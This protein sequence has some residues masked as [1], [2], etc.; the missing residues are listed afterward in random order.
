MANYR[1][2]LRRSRRR[3]R[4]RRILMVAMW[5]LLNQK[6]QSYY[7]RRLLN[8]EGRQRRDRNL[9]RAALHHPQHSTWEKCFGSGDDGV[10]I[11]VT[12]FDHAT[13]EFMLSHFD[14][15]FSSYT[16]WCS[17][18]GGVDGLNYRCL[19]L[20]HHQ[21]QRRHSRQ[22]CQRQQ[23]VH[24]VQQPLHL[25]VGFL[26]DDCIHKYWL[27]FVAGWNC[28]RTAEPSLDESLQQAMG[29]PCLRLQDLLWE[30]HDQS[31]PC[32]VLELRRWLWQYNSC[33]NFSAVEYH[34]PCCCWAWYEYTKLCRES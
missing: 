23:E 25:G 12:G 9:I 26:T 3:R 17:K 19:L 14:P 4:R 11:T 15:L 7:Y 6:P 29:S 24:C 33:R 2:Y 5:L 20:F 18:F 21:R 30:Q 34:G 10:L 1:A 22:Q 28:S 27:G 13:F 8:E 32:L 16:P 31:H